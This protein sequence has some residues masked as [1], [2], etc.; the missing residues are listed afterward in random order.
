MSM[1]SLYDV[2]LLGVSAVFV[3]VMAVVF[4][5]FIQRVK[6]TIKEQNDAN[7]ILT[8]VLVDLRDFS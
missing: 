5:W 6:Q 8:D 1:T 2:V 7:V 4:L 3:L